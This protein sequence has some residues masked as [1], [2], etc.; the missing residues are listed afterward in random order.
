MMALHVRLA[1]LTL[2]LVVALLLV[3][4]A[5]AEWP[6]EGGNP[7]HTG[8]QLT[9]LIGPANQWEVEV[10]GELKCPPATAYSK[11]YVGTSDGFLK[12]LDE[13]DGHLLWDVKLGD[14]VCA[15]PLIESQT[16]FVPEG[17]VLHAVA[18]NNKSDKWTF[19]AVGALRASPIL[20]DD[21]IYIGSED[22]RVYAIDKYTGNLEWSLKLD[23]VVSTSPAIAGNTLVIG[24]ESGTVYGIHRNEGEE[25]WQVDVGSSVS[26][27][28]CI[29]GNTAMVGTYGGRLQGINT[30]DGEIVWTYPNPAEPALDPILTT[31]V[32]N[33]GLVYFGSDGLYCLEVR[34]GLKA[35]IHETGDTI[36]GAP[37]IVESFLVFGSYDG[38]IRCLDKNTGRVLWRF[39]SD[40]VFRSGVT[41]DY[42]KAFIGGRDGKLY[43][44][45]IL[46]SKAPIINAPYNLKAEAHDSILFQVAASDPEG[47]L[48]T[49]SWDFGDGNTSTETSPLHEYPVAGEYT[50]EVTVSDGTKSKKHT[51]TVTVNPFETITTGGDEDG[52]SWTILAGAIAGAVVL[53]IIVLLFFLRKRGGEDGEGDGEVESQ[54]Q[55]QYPDPSQLQP[56]PQPEQYQQPPAGDA[57]A[58]VAPVETP[59]PAQEDSPQIT[60]EEGD[61]Q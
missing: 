52:M 3:P 17:Q 9:P 42:D 8:E 55:P 43:A 40:T 57:Y 46:N 5:T 60:W 24:T 10:D 39:S 30:G 41:I 22:K 21:L 36:R 6:M 7:S 16:A 2:V 56:Q 37:A 31:P 25:L 23:D 35:W 59:A 20:Y 28:A 53:V 49:Y 61:T 47:N 14:G 45:S 54:P 15:T 26:T 19:E 1:T 34:N 32:T 50:I 48:L 29:S 13:R 11:L 27:A 51:I 38:L 4:T 12:V 18:L 58:D 33:S 44:R